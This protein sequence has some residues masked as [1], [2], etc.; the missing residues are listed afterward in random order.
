V[1]SAGGV[2]N[3]IKYWYLLEKNPNLVKE[4]IVLMHIFRQVS[5]DDYGSHLALWDFVWGKME[6]ALGEGRI[7][8]KRYTYGSGEGLDRAIEDFK[9]HLRRGPALVA[10]VG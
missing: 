1:E 2:T 6:D 9:E 5:E 3:L 7:Q 8:A 10:A 4:P